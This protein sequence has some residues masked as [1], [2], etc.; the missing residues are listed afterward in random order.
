MFVCAKTETSVPEDSRPLS[1]PISDHG[2]TAS[3]DD[4]AHGCCPRNH[5]PFCLSQDASPRSRSLSRSSRSDFY[6]VRG[7]MTTT[8]IAIAATTRPP[9]SSTAPNLCAPRASSLRT[10][11]TLAMH[12]AW[13][14]PTAHGLALALH[15]VRRSTVHLRRIHALDNAAP[16]NA[17]WAQELLEDLRV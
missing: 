11:S 1:S 5:R 15:H 10:I 7:T 3:H 4:S 9:P 16:S 8:R 13:A 17:A 2:S 12:L 6:G 14:H